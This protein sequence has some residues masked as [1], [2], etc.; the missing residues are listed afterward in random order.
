MSKI[1]GSEGI[2]HVATWGYSLPS[3][4]NRQSKGCHGERQD[5]R[6]AQGTGLEPQGGTLEKTKSV[7]W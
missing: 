1:I 7:R 6:E 2:H 3:R 4:S 5:Y